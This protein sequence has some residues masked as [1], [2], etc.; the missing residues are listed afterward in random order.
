M[1]SRKEY[2]KK[3][4]RSEAFNEWLDIVGPQWKELGGFPPNP[5]S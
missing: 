3:R 1:L 2:I 4:F 5:V